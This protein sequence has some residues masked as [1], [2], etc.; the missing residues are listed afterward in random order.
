MSLIQP[1]KSDEIKMRF[2]KIPLFQNFHIK[3]V[4]V[5]MGLTIAP[6]QYYRHKNV[7]KGAYVDSKTGAS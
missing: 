5:A 4:V 1:V 2:Y 6:G 3:T 7:Q